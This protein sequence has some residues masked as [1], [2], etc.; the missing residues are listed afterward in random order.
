[1][2]RGKKSRRYTP[3]PSPQN[4][5]MITG[6]KT[7]SVFIRRLHARVPAE[8]AALINPRLRPRP[9]VAVATQHASRKKWLPDVRHPSKATQVSVCI[10][11]GR[12]VA[13]GLGGAGSLLWGLGV[14]CSWLVSLCFPFLLP[15]VHYRNLTLVRAVG[16]A[17]LLKSFSLCNW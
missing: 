9:T 4:Y 2:K 17:W 7:L 5:S 12:A 10:I 11:I 16:V 15:S 1:M 8:L 14:C 3:Y 13:G 6:G